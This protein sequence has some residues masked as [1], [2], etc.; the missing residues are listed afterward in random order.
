LSAIDCQ[1]YAKTL[2][3]CYARKTLQRHIGTG[4]TRAARN[5]RRRIGG[6]RIRHSGSG[7]IRRAVFTPACGST[8]W[9]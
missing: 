3:Y 5:E 4:A 6:A 1:A 8:G 7:F 9:M 2:G